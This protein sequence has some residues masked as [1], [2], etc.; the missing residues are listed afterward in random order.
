M[1]SKPLRFPDNISNESHIDTQKRKLN[2]AGRI[3]SIN[4]KNY[5]PKDEVLKEWVDPIEHL[6]RVT[7]VE[8][9]YVKK[10]SKVTL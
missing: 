10:I 3:I 6:K 7:Q 8:N 4:F 5:V 2:S 9:L 1:S